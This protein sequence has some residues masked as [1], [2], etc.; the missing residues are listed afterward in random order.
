VQRRR[1][2]AQ[3]EEAPRPGEGVGLLDQTGLADARLAAHRDH[4][5]STVRRGVER[6]RDGSHLDGAPDERNQRR[7]HPTSF[8]ADRRWAYSIRP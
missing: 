3:R 2:G 7:R 6:G 4:A 1:G 8:L 5:G